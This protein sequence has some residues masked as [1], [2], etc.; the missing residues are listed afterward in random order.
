RISITGTRSHSSSFLSQ[1]RQNRI[2]GDIIIVFGGTNDWGQL[3]EP[4]TKEI[5]S[6]SYE[7]LVR[8]MV[9]RHNNSRLYF[10]TPLQRWD[11]SLDEV[12]MH[13]WSQNDLA[14]TIKEAVRSCPE[15]NLI[16]L[17]A[18]PITEDDG[19]LFDGLHP[20]RQGMRLIAALVKEGLNLS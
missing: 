15:A 9:Q 14:R 13:N 17:G 6:A 7:K 12:N 18:Y 4:T 3:E 19:L 11:K 2:K 5:F 1:K 10:C 20:T 8:L 16:D